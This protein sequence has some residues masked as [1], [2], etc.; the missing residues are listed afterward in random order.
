PSPTPVPADTFVPEVV[1]P[2]PVETPPP[3]SQPEI[4]P[5]SAVQYLEPTVLEYPRASRRLGESGHV[6]VRV[7]INEAGLPGEM[8]VTQSSG[9]NRLDAAALAAVKLTRFKPYTENGNAVAGWAFIPL[10]F[11]LEK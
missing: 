11:D 8:Q 9:Y 7:Y 4:I 3:A 2:P 6:M 5:A 1:Q 10:N